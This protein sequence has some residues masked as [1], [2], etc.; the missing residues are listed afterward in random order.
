LACPSIRSTL[1]SVTD[2]RKFNRMELR[3]CMTV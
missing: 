3:F 1:N 2:D